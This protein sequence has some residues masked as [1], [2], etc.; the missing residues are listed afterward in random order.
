MGL[1]EQS[2]TFIHR[3]IQH[4]KHHHCLI[5]IYYTLFSVIFGSTIVGRSLAEY[6]RLRQCLR[7]TW[8]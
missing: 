6:F 4:S 2:S 1:L 3:V 8:I 7:E 5:Y